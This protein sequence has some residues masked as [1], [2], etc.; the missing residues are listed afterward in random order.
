MQG[1]EQRSSSLLF[2][3]TLGA[4]TAAKHGTGQAGG[5]VQSQE[6]C[7]SRRDGQNRLLPE[8]K[9]KVL[10][11]FRA[12]RYGLTVGLHQDSDAPRLFLGGQFFS[13]SLI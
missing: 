9:Q 12:P 8:K 2:P 1:D 11:P 3:I 5:E 4:G 10:H 7:P 13:H 6:K